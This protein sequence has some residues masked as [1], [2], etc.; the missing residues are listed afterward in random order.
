M[1][2]APLYHC[3]GP[4]YRPRVAL[5]GMRQPP[6]LHSQASAFG[7]QHLFNPG[8]SPSHGMVTGGSCYSIVDAFIVPWR[9]RARSIT[10]LPALFRSIRLYAPSAGTGHETPAEYDTSHRG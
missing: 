7:I 1:L 9:G 3:Y 4:I 8:Q 5:Q 6:D 10:L 2:A